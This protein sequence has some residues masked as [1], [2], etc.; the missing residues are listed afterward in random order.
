MKILIANDDSIFAEG[1]R[2]LASV[3]GKEHEVYICAPDRE[4]S[5]TGHSMS[6]NKPLMVSPLTKRVPWIE[7]ITDGCVT[8]GTPAD[9]VKIALRQVFKDIKFDLVLSGINHGPNLGID[10]LYSGTVSAA[11]EAMLM[12][13]PSIAT[14]LYSYSSKEFTPAAEWVRDFIKKEEH[15]RNLPKNT[16]LNINFPPVSRE[17]YVADE[18]TVLGHR[19]YKENFEERVDPRGRSYYWLAGDPVEDKEVPGT[20]GYAVMNNKVSITPVTFD[21]THYDYIENLKSII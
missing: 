13:Y 12:G 17:E 20:D 11:M 6:L 5:A 9:C 21:M 3:I 2:T 4:R 10:V 14:S 7:N 19:A 15:F 1:I 8:S 16:F 18:V